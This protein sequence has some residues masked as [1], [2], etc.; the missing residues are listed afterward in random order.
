MPQ[1]SWYD[2]LT[3]G[4]GAAEKAVQQGAQTAGHYVY[5]VAHPS[6]NTEKLRNSLPPT[7]LDTLKRVESLIPRAPDITPRG[8]V[9]SYGNLAG[10]VYNA[11]SHPIST[12]EDVAKGA[13]L[14]LPQLATGVVGQAAN[15]V[16]PTRV[17]Q[18]LRSIDPK[19]ADKALATARAAENYIIGR[20]GSGANIGDTLTKDPFGALSD[21]S[22][23][24][25]GGEGLAA[26]L[27]ASEN[28]LQAIQ[29]ARKV[30]DLPVTLPIKSAVSVL[31]RTPLARIAGKPQ[32]FANGALTKE[33]AASLSA[34]GLHPDTAAHPDV[35]R[36]F[37][38]ISDEKGASPAA[39]KEAVLKA[40][41]VADDDITRGATTS[42]LKT[43]NNQISDAYNK[44]HANAV[45]AIRREIS[46]DFAQR[47][48][49]DKA[50]ISSAYKKAFANQGVFLPESLESLPGY[51]SE[52]LADSD[53][54]SVSEIIKYT[55]SRPNAARILAGGYNPATGFTKKSI[56]ETLRDVADETGNIS[57]NNIGATR[58]E[59]AAAG[60]QATN[61]F[62]QNAVSATRGGYDNWLENISQNPELTDGDLSQFSK[63]YADARNAHAT[64]KQTYGSEAPDAVQNAVKKIEDSSTEGAYVPDAQTSQ[65]IGDA[66][67]PGK[68]DLG[69]NYHG[70]L[71]GPYGQRMDP[72]T[73]ANHRVK[74]DALDILD[75]AGPAQVATPGV[76]PIIFKTAYK[77]FSL[78]VLAATV[79]EIVGKGLE[80]FGGP[81]FSPVSAIMGPAGV[82]AGHVINNALE[83]RATR[84][85]LAKELSGAP[86]VYRDIS[87]DGFVPAANIG[88]AY[89]RWATAPS[90]NEPEKKEPIAL[91]P[92]DAVNYSQPETDNTA[93]PS[94][95]E[96]KGERPIALSPEEA[97]NY[98]GGAEQST[99]SQRA[100]GGRIG[101]ATGGSAKENF[102]P[103][104]CKLMS[105]AKKVKREINKST[106]PLLNLHD[107]TVAKA[108]AIAQKS[109]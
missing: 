52:S 102:E 53:H 41:G 37:K 89:S 86:N 3:S 93:A 55:D 66:L 4:L 67:I 26:K 22:L 75:K 56:F 68:T 9:S 62:D 47:Y 101:F 100:A 50:E 81:L 18:E 79:S 33:G 28:I 19:D 27:G 5:Q 88:A 96:P 80:H 87:A 25:S 38:D 57:L 6:A 76:L 30:A 94:A 59:I 58:D 16:L 71:D 31:K 106:E 7:A 105:R 77:K 61:K 95:N 108:L 85:G 49:T 40:A 45:D 24:L 51:V 12:V 35:L 73:L 99:G 109:I 42:G 78:P 91:S 90:A 54:P 98:S 92:E 63:D 44:A 11:V 32:A 83:Q 46:P 48:A 1:R 104:I 34:A 60:R 103:L 39:A 70:L 8:P 72:E 97:M 13:V 43:D 107:N 74:A 84:M 29:E 69:A 20:Y 21:A 23:L 2:Y 65:A 64:F 15:A 82:F 17:T 10:G 36:H 14:T